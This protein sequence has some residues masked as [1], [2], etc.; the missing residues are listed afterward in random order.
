MEVAS[1]AR[2]KK[3]TTL[4][5]LEISHAKPQRRTQRREA[6]LGILPEKIGKMSENEIAEDIVVTAFHIDCPVGPESPAE[7]QS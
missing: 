2:T 1:P 3:S 4:C 5:Y 6:V 7:F